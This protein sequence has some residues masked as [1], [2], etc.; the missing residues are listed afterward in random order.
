MKVSAKNLTITASESEIEFSSS[1][2][3]MR[4]LRVGSFHRKIQLYMDAPKGFLVIEGT[5]K[6]YNMKNVL[7]LDVISTEEEKKPNHFYNINVICSTPDEMKNLVGELS[8]HISVLW[9]T[10]TTKKE[11]AKKRE[12]S[13]PKKNYKKFPKFDVGFNHIEIPAELE[14]SIRSSAK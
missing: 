7:V 5:P 4:K 9:K 2:G 1:K 14:E 10:Y 6:L 8:K 13:A 11:E 3:E 12:T